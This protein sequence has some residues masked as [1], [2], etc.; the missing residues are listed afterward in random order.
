MQIKR[1]VAAFFAAITL[2]ITASA[3]TLVPVGRTV[4]VKL[5]SDGVMVVGVEDG[6]SSQLEKGDIITHIND[7]E[8]DTV[9]QL[10]QLIDSSDGQQL[11]MTVNRDG[12][13]VQISVT[14]ILSQGSY[15]LGLWIRDSMTGI[16]TVTYYDPETGMF[17]A[18]GHGVNDVDTGR[19]LPLEEGTIMSA[20]VASVK[21]GSAGSPGQLVGDFM[22]MEEIGTV[23]KNTDYGIF[24]YLDADGDI[25]TDAIAI[26]SPDEVENGSA[27]II[28]NVE[29]DKAELFDVE[30]IRQNDSRDDRNMLIRVTDQKLLEL[31][32]GIVQ[33]M[34]GSPII[35]NGKLVGAVTH[36]L[37]NNS[38][39]GYGIYIENMLDAAEQ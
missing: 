39:T 14:P 25:S 16:G 22:N 33:G 29:G 10:R 30:I 18:L 3:K 20:S 17:G 6:I 2:T 37:I 21:K 24:G 7:T 12:Q 32:G 34:S 36:V 23:L 13:Q 8:I 26:A 35:Q 27:Q 15:K 31:T 4:A 5:L 38:A 9:G 1:M 19:L 11:C 28:S